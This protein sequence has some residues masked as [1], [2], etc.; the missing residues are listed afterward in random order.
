MPTR[1]LLCARPR[2]DPELVSESAPGLQHIDLGNGRFATL[3][4]PPVWRREQPAPLAVMLHGA[5]GNAGHGLAL[6]EPFAAQ[7]GLLVLAPSSEGETWD[8]LLDG[9]GPDVRAIDSALDWVFARYRVD[10]ARLALG[11]FSDGASYA[12]SL[13]LVNGD[14]FHRAVALS[15]GYIARAPRQGEVKAFVSHGTADLVLPIELCGQRIVKVLR[16]AGYGVEYLE[17]EGGH[18]VPPQVAREAVAWL[19]R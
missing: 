8:V 6:L 1:A 18:V 4:V 14:L 17:F 12:L 10:P 2:T 9:W 19:L 16:Q 5:G 15:P 3:H 7:Q 13:A 11:G